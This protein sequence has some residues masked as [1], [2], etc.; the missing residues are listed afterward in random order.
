MCTFFS[1][2]GTFDRLCLK[3]VVSSFCFH[4][5][6]SSSK[7]VVFGFTE[8]DFEVAPDRL[9]GEIE[10]FDA[11]NG[12]RRMV[13]WGTEDQHAGQS[14]HHGQS[15]SSSSGGVVIQA[16]GPEAAYKRPQ[17]VVLALGDV[18]MSESAA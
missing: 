4:L 13:R 16:H 8:D 7:S 12:V 15:A 18:D 17:C 2:H 5:L 9:G 10:V 6:K 14:A 1:S 3:S 11:E